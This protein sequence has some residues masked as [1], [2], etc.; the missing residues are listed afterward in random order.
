M[1]T[2]LTLLAVFALTLGL[3]ADP[4]ADV[5][6]LMDSPVKMSAVLERR[7]PNDDVIMKDRKMLEK[8]IQ[9]EKT[10][11][12]FDATPRELFGWLAQQQGRT[13]TELLLLNNLAKVNAVELRAKLL[14]VLEKSNMAAAASDLEEA[15]VSVETSKTLERAAQDRFA[16]LAKIAL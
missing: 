12:G 6:A 11:R 10:Q 9:R 13:S 4:L 3:R 5:K 16:R 8:I 7:S 2:L 1:K 15:L 14:P